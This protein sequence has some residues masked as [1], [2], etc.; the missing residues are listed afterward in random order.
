MEVWVEAWH[1]WKR[2]ARP[3]TGERGGKS[4]IIVMW[5]ISFEYIQQV[6]SSVADLLSLMT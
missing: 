6:W 5:Q 4:S 3:D 1:V 2:K